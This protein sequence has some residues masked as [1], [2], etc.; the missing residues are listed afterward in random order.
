M[1]NKTND[2]QNR[3]QASQ[4]TNKTKDKQAKG[5][6]KQRTNRFRD[7]HG[8]VAKIVCIIAPIQCCCGH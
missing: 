6:T 4:W 8:Q 1:T 5:Q 2:K 3:G 7:E